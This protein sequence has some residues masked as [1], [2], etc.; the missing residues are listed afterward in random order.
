[1]ITRYGKEFWFEKYEGWI[2]S[3]SGPMANTEELKKL[4]DELKIVNQ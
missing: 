1:M 2:S 4:A 3:G